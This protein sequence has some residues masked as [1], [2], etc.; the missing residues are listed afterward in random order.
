[1]HSTPK[2]INKQ[3]AC[4]Q[5]L[6]PRLHCFCA[7]VT[8][9]KNGLK[10]LILQ[11]PQEQYKLLNSASLAHAMLE[12]SILK[13]GLS[14]RNLSHALGVEADPKQW[15]VLYLKGTGGQGKPMEMFDA[16]K[17]PIAGT[18][19]LKGII[20]IDGSWKQAKTMW[21]RNPWLLRL[22]RIMLNP[23]RASRRPQT[24][25]EGLSTIEAVALA[26]ECL[27]E[28]SVIPSTLIKNYEDL[29]LPPGGSGQRGK[30]ERAV[31]EPPL[32]KPFDI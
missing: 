30:A 10:V 24:K 25:K 5:C 20:V 31:R 7:K 26:L 13:V 18:A 15:G 28:D 11:H 29:I 32:Q 8:A 22:N 17:R 9:L 14:W 3:D 12:N 1:M 27:G 21:W 4:P 23:A 2:K 19:A 16:K 6:R